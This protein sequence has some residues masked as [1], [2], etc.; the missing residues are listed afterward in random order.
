MAMKSFAVPMPDGTEMQFDAPASWTES[1]AR[2]YAMREYRRQ[3]GKAVIGKGRQILEGVVQGVTGGFGDEAAG[4]GTGIDAALGGGSFT[5]GYQQGKEAFNQRQAEAGLLGTGA[6]VAG[7]MA[8]GGIGVGLAKKYLPELAGKITPAV[9]AAAGGA[10][11]GAGEAEDLAAV[12][13]SMV[14]GAV[15]GAAAGP[16]AALIGRLGTGGVKALRGL[17]RQAFEGN[18][19]RA[20][21][22][23][24]ETAERAGYTPEELANAIQVLGPDA[25]AADVNLAMQKGLRGATSASPAAAQ[26]A[27]EVLEARVRGGGQRLTSAAT[28]TMDVPT[29]RLY[30]TVEGINTARRQAAQ[31]DYGPIYDTV[32]EPTEDLEKILGR[33]A[34]KKGLKNAME[35]VANEGDELPMIFT[36]EGELVPGLTLKQL[37]QVKQGIDAVIE[38][39]TN[40]FGK[41]D[42][43]GRSAVHAKKA[44]I[45]WIENNTEVGDQYRE[46]RQLYAGYSASI[47][48]A[49]KGANVFNDDADETIAWMKDATDAEKEMYRRGAFNAVRDEIE[50]AAETGT[51][52][53]RAKLKTPKFKRRLRAAFD[54]DEQFEEFVDALESERSYQETRNMIQGGSPTERI[55]QEV[56]EFQGGAG[57]PPRFSGPIEMATEGLRRAWNYGSPASS[58]AD[59]IAGTYTDLMLGRNPPAA[60]GPAGRAGQG[61]AGRVPMDAYGAGVGATSNLIFQPEVQGMLDALNPWAEDF[62]IEGRY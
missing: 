52:A 8:T 47:S 12:P 15:L 49:K 35:I 23:F 56:L 53:L 58:R 30:D 29:D 7:G 45:D 46:A 54:S 33:P 59:E 34:A 43:R 2:A 20:M 55:R 24:R 4:L 21:R 28:R 5:E 27:D 17:W 39:S 62:E 14:E 25:T 41:V 61:I 6:Q 16:A 13:E 40:E 32:I 10:V 50:S 18:D 42:A 31:R 37:D 44:L 48:A 36:A 1:K 19:A 60:L 11:A 9:G 22:M 3:Q 51:A 57:A 26:K 38:D